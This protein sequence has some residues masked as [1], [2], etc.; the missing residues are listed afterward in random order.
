MLHTLLEALVVVSLLSGLAYF[1]RFLDLSGSMAA[2]VVG[3]IIYWLG[4]YL[5][6]II[7]LIFFIVSSLFTKYRYRDK[8]HD[9]ADSLRSWRNVVGNGAVA[10]A[11]LILT[12]LTAVC[13]GLDL[14]IYVG[15]ISAAF[16][17]TMATE[18]GMLS[19][20]RPKSI[21]SFKD[22]EKGQSGGV[23]LL[24]YSGVLLSAF[25][26]WTGIMLFSLL[27]NPLQINTGYIGLLVII[28]LSALA[29][30]TSDSIIGALMQAQYRCKK[31]G[32]IVEVR[33]HCSI[34]TTRI[35][36]YSFVNN[37]VVNLLATL[38][39]AIT[40]YVIFKLW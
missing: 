6:F 11:V 23:S 8:Y 15:A 32:N 12:H 10:A 33:T 35:R 16:A 19:R 13:G 30:S 28:L 22:V 18:V 20:G 17:D 21:I 1:G 14:V 39:G 29:G 37:D 36:G 40:S 3:F 26:L 5:H 34:P 25:I 4:G 7:L 9:K 27:Y 24:G 2:F 38:S 31:C